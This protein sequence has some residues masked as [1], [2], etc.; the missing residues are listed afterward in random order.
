MDF[1]ELCRKFQTTKKAMQGRRGSQGL[2]LKRKLIAYIL[3]NKYC[4]SYP[5]IAQIMKK[6]HTT[7]IYYIRE[8]NNTKKWLS[9]VDEE[10]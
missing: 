9:L 3:R 6:D 2:A 10:L 7:I 5:E 1:G 4:L 8:I